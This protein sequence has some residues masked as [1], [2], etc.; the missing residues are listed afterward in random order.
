MADDWLFQGMKR[1]LQ[2]KGIT[3]VAMKGVDR[4]GESL[5]MRDSI[6]QIQVRNC[7]D[8]AETLGGVHFPEYGIICGKLG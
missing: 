8:L 6:K 1:E 5:K 2:P 3:V 4:V 7:R